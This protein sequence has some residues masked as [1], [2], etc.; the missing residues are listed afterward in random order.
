MFKLT[1]LV[2]PEMLQL[3]EEETQSLVSSWSKDEEEAKLFFIL[4]EVC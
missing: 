2:F 3:E 4:F 1:Y